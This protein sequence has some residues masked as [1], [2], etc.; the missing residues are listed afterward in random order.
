MTVIYLLLAALGTG[1]FSCLWSFMIGDPHEGAVHPGRILS[2]LGRYLFDKYYQRES[3]IEVEKE[4]RRG[5][6]FTKAAQEWQ[7]SLNN[8][9][10]PYP[11]TIET[12]KATP[13]EAVNWWKATGVCP[14]CFNVWA[15]VLS[16][17]LTWRFA[18]LPYLALLAL[19]LFM[20]FANVALS[21]ALRARD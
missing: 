6:E 15:S 1:L 11:F 5:R 7:Q 18:E 3:A 13:Y 21:L 20:G 4:L 8:G 14:R 2:G 12:F 16:F 19:P 17:V 10:R 9:A